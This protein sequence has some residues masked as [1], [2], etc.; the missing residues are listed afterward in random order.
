MTSVAGIA[1][2]HPILNASGTLD[3]LAAH[4]VLGDATLG[5]SAHVTKTIFPEPRSGNAAPRIAETAGG[6]LNSI[7]LPGPGIAAFLA[8]VLPRTLAVVGSTP[9]IVSI[10]G[11]SIADYVR[12]ARA[13]DGVAGVAALELNLSCPNIE[14]GCIAIGADIGETSDVTARVRA[15]TSLPLLVK[16]SPSVSDIVALARAAAA[17][18]ADA[19]TLTNTARGLAVRTDTGASVLGGPG[20]GLSGPPLRPL[21]LAAVFAVRRALAID[22]VGVGGVGSPSDAGELLAAGATV[23]AVGTATFRDPTTIRRI[24]AVYRL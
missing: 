20:G 21:T 6:M 8:D 22:I 19:L 14:S 17:A 18:G 9:V 7:G 3:A 24:A 11:A 2:A 12:L 15:D 10:G 1:L 23:V 5:A 4:A 13:L 16:L